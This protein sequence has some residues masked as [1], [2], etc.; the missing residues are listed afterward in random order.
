MDE[1]ELVQRAQDGDEQSF[2]QLIESYRTRLLAFLTG[3][4]PRTL[5]RKITAEDV[6]QE[7][8]VTAHARLASFEYRGDG[9]F[10]AWLW[11]I[12]QL[13][14]REAVRRFAG[15]A[16]RG[17]A[18]EISRGGRRD[19]GLFEAPQGTPSE[20]AMA[21]ELEERV[22]QALGRLS[23]DYR[24][25][26]TLV[27]IEQ[28]SLREAAVAMDKSYEAT[29]KLYGRAVAALAHEITRGADA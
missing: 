10:R 18:A 3:R 5:K 20:Y 25:V 16:K 27:R 23:D 14:L 17:G 1:A 7:V 15:T 13:K 8:S 2:A 19:T 4:I 21:G 24:A 26:L 12:A 9:A 29:K 28:Q 6:F 11:Q 22:H